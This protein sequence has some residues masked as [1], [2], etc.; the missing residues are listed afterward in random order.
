MTDTYTDEAIVVLGAGPAGMAAAMG[1]TKAGFKVRL[2]ER[3][4]EARPAGNILNLWPPAVFALE[5]MGVDIV[6]LGAPCHTTFRDA[7]GNIRATVNL[8][9]EVIDRY[10]GG[11]IGLLR[12]Y[13]YA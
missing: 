13:L 8:P 6:D 12:P 10:Q 5:E 7:K 9:Q 11:F 2:Y 4:A 1:L 3:Y